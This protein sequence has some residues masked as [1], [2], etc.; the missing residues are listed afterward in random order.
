MHPR[1]REFLAVKRHS[2]SAGQV[3]FDGMW[4]VEQA[5]AAGVE[6]Q[7]VFVSLQ[8]ADGVALAT[9][10]VGMGAQGYAVSEKVLSRLADREG[11]GDIAALGLAPWRTLGHID[12]RCHT[13]VVIADGWDLPGNLETLIRCAD[14]A[15]ALRYLRTR[16]RYAQPLAER[17]HFRE[18]STAR[19]AYLLC[20]VSTQPLEGSIQNG[21]RKFVGTRLTVAHHGRG[22]FADNRDRGD[23]ERRG[24]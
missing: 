24:R 18:R 3:T 7:A 19:L 10:A 1:V 5:L 21:G 12:V 23:G 16:Q 2:A 4:M 22:I 17:Q 13:R 11:L 8:S 20:G 6:L 15:G 14:A 9:K